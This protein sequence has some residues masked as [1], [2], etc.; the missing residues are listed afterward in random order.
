MFCE[1]CDKRESC[2]EVCAE[3]EAFVNQDHV[4]Q[5][6]L[7]PSRPLDLS[8]EDWTVWDYSKD[9]YT[10]KELK[11]FIIALHDEGKSYREI[12]Y[13]LG[14]DIAYISRVLTKFKTNTL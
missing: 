11:R 9:R 1:T 8:T 6:H 4:S 13:H 10:P 3:A 7:I 5:R 14:C 2:V 12:A